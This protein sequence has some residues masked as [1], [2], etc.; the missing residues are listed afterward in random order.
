M[1]KILLVIF[2]LLSLQ[3]ANAQNTLAKIKFEDAEKAYYDGD[4]Q[5]CLQLLN[6]TE[7]ILGQSAPNILFLKILAGHKLLEADKN[8][9]YSQLATLR[10]QTNFY[11]NDYD[12]AGLEDKYRQVYEVSNALKVYPANEEDFNQKGEAIQKEKELVKS[13]I[14]DYFNAIG[15]LE[16]INTINT[17]YKVSRPFVVNGKEY[18]VYKMMLPDKISQS[19]AEL[20]S[21]EKPYGS[22]VINGDYGIHVIKPNNSGKKGPGPIKSLTAAEYASLNNMLRISTI[23]EK[24]FFEV[25]YQLSYHGIENGL[26]KIQI[27][28]PDG[29]EEFRFYNDSSKL[30]DKVQITGDCL[31]QFSKYMNFTSMEIIYNNYQAVDG[32]LLPFEITYMGSGSFNGNTFIN[33]RVWSSSYS[34]ISINMNV[35]END[36]YLANNN[37]TKSMSRSQA[38]EKTKAKLETIMIERLKDN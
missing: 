37:N 29:L 18:K 26:H 24:S 21:L 25:N 28:Y 31:V 20:K 14:T 19:G 1:K 8:Y 7:K 9:P 33:E 10:D 17:L 38:I 6:E 12:I 30:L 13:V 35:D 11:L 2:A 3:A 22:Y 15:G 34:E 16:R 4:Y 36:F 23:P 5:N 27:K 32:I